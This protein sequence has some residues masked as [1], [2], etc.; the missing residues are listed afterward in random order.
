[1]KLTDR[2]RWTE[3]VAMTVALVALA[4]TAAV[5]FAWWLSQIG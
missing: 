2:N 5:A 4:I 3:A 1:M